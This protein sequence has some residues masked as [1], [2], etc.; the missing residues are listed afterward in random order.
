VQCCTSAN[1]KAS[2]LKSANLTNTSR[3]K[4][5]RKPKL[6]SLETGPSWPFSFEFFSYHLS[7]SS[8]H[9]TIKEL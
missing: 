9:Y 5:K 4:Q 6:L 8:K 1:T 3:K 2:R 7:I